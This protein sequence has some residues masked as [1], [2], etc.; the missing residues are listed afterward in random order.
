MEKLSIPSASPQVARS[1]DLA[2]PPVIRLEG[3]SIA[4]ARDTEVVDYVFSSLNR[5]CGGM[6]VTA[7]LDFLARARTDPECRRLYG[8]ADII[9]A[10]GMPLVWAAWLQGT[11]IP[12][13]IAGSDLVWQL[14]EQAVR[15]GRSLYLLG[16]AGDS[17]RRAA[18]V[19]LRRSPG[20]RIAGC[21]SPVI[22]SPVTAEELATIREEIQR[23]RPDLVYVGF[24]SPKQEYLMRALRHEFPLV[25]MLGCGISLSFVAGDVSR[26]P[27]WMQ[28]AGFEWL[29]RLVIEPRRLFSRYILR[30]LPYAIGLM[31]RSV[32]ARYF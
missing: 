7:N 3:L 24:G 26:A 6:L 28:R 20:I 32:L 29:H 10:D 15:E 18:D 22:S 30:N 4:A 13:R 12:Q 5:R 21:S 31:W 19:L 11:P 16:G 23:S 25:W 17:A 8:D 2:S 14:A 9:V 1:R 27:R